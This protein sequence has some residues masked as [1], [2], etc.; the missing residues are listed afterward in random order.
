MYKSHLLLKFM[1]A[2]YFIKVTYK[3]SKSD[4]RDDIIFS[5]KVVDN[6]RFIDR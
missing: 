1:A 5:R 4:Y 6:F 2:I 3:V